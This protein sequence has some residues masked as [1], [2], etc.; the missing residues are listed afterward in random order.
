[1]RELFVSWCA[2]YGRDPRRTHAYAAFAQNVREAVAISL[3]TS[4]PFWSGLN[5]FSDL[6]AAE[7]K[8]RYTGGLS[9]EHEDR[10]RLIQ[11]AAGEPKL[12]GGRSMLEGSGL[13]LPGSAADLQHSHPHLQMPLLAC[14][15]AMAAMLASCRSLGGSRHWLSS[16]GPVAMQAGAE[17]AGMA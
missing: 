16:R 2:H 7:F 13:G 1:M 11:T 14:P 12:R 17:M 3:D 5:G 4:V 6:S 15:V 9:P 10:R 8:S